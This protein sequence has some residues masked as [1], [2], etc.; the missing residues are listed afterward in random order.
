MIDIFLRSAMPVSDIP[1]M[2]SGFDCDRVLVRS[3]GPTSIWQRSADGWAVDVAG[4][5]LYED[6]CADHIS[7]CAFRSDGLITAP[8]EGEMVLLLEGHEAR[9]WLKSMECYRYAV[10]D[11]IGC[12]VC[13][14]HSGEEILCA[15]ALFALSE[16]KSLN[17]A[18]TELAKKILAWVDQALA[19]G[20]DQIEAA[21]AINA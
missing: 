6:L 7:L 16:F 15:S 20:A 2:L 14:D 1:K 12:T 21:I 18:S 13:V 9:E 17:S 11:A 8:V 4:M 5:T 10:E 19:A 3:G